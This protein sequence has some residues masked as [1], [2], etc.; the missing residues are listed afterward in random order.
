M[1]IKDS[2][3][4]AAVAAVVADV[5]IWLAAS[6]YLEQFDVRVS[7]SPVYFIAADLILAII[8]TATVAFNSIRIAMSNPVESIKN[9]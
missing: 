1:F 5:L 7:L 2:L 4:M 3:K 8:V 9:E 6:R